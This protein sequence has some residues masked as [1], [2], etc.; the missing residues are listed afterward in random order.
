MTVDQIVIGVCGDPELRAGPFIGTNE[1][2]FCLFNTV[3]EVEPEIMCQ[4]KD[5]NEFLKLCSE[6]M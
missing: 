3:D 6:Y 5:W 4:H 1:V 2:G